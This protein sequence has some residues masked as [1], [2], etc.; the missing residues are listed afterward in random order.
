MADVV[1][2]IDAVEISRIDHILE[3]SPG[4]VTRFFSQEEVATGAELGGPRRA[5][6]FAGRFAVREALLKA[7]GL[8]LSGGVTLADIAVLPADSGHP[9]VELRGEA[10][11]LVARL[12]IQRISVSIT[13]ERDLAVAVALVTLRSDEECN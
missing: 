12:G 10:K 6:F 2:G 7:L 4:F 3:V 11:K 13:H 1:V 5:E 8:G 9:R